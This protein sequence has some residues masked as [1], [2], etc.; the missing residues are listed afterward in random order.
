VCARARAR[1]NLYVRTNARV[2]G[3]EGAGK[4]AGSVQPVEEQSDDAW[5]HNFASARAQREART[6]RLVASAR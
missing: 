5:S 1:T 3:E 4:V 2:D 6:E